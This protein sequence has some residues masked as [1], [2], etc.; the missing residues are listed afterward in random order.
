MERKC[1]KGTECGFN[2][3]EMITHLH[4]VP[5]WRNVFW[6]A[7]GSGAALTVQIYQTTKTAVVMG[8]ADIGVTGF[9]WW[10]I[11]G[12]GGPVVGVALAGWMAWL[13][14]VLIALKEKSTHEIFSF[15]HGLTYAGFAN[16]VVKVGVGHQYLRGW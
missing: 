4:V 8:Y 6:V 1:P 16:L 2:G 12:T 9:W 7:A 13:I 15:V 10:F 3:I 5:T 14:C 11:A